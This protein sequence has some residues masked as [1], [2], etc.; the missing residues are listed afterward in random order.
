M[1]KIITIKVIS[2]IFRIVSVTVFMQ[3]ILSVGEAILSKKT[4]FGRHFAAITVKAMQEYEVA[5]R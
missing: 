4:V 2:A 5:K 1:S 3:N